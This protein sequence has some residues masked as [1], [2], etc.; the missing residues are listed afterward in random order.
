MVA[1]QIRGIDDAERDVLVRRAKERGQSLQGFLLDLVRAE[2][3]RSRNAE[4]LRGFEG[5]DDGLGEGEEG[6]VADII[7]A[8]REERME[9]YGIYEGLDGG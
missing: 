4:V 8:G 7:R 1:L 2:V 3:R 9:R 5:R 6:S